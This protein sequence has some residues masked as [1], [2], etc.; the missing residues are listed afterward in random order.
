MWELDGG[1]EVD[2]TGEE[3]DGREGDG[4]EDWDSNRDGDRGMDAVTDSSGG[5]DEES[6][7]SGPDGNGVSTGKVDGD[8]DVDKSALS[9][10]VVITVSSRGLSVV[11]VV[12]VVV[13]CPFL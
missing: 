5:G 3:E 1:E 6:D 8:S 7:W 12:V 4:E 13:D 2:G 10:P 9:D 11:V